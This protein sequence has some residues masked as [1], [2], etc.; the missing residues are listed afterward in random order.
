MQP[1]PQDNQLMSKH[2]V[3]RFK[4]Q[5]RLEW[6]A[7]DGHNDTEQPDHST[8]LGDSITSS[9]RMRFSVHTATY[10][11]RSRPSPNNA[12]WPR[13]TWPGLPAS[14]SRTSIGILNYRHD[15]YEVRRLIKLLC[16]LGADVCISLA[17]E[18]GL[19]KGIVLSQTIH[20]D[21]EATLRDLA[22]TNEIDYQPEPRL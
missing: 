6:R 11:T 22:Q 17:R 2:R 14:P 1:T 10:A 19:D 9:T 7:Q 4:P 21:K 3:L 15:G 18:S 13:Q 8:S 5:L 20:D 12:A 16:A